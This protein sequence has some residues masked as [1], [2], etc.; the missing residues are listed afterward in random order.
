[1]LSSIIL[2]ILFII[3][4]ILTVLLLIVEI[5]LFCKAKGDEAKRKKL[6]I[7]IIITGTVVGLVVAA[8]IAISILMMTSIMYM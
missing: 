4:V 2:T 8:I 3:I 7:A 1:M 6:K 5:V